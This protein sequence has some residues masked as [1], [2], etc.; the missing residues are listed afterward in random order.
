MAMGARFICLLREEEVQTGV[1]AR[2]CLNISN[3]SLIDMIKFVKS[4]IVGL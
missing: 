3:M 4:I 2:V 1:D